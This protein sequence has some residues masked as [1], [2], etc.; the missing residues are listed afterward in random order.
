MQQNKAIEF[1]GIMLGLGEYYSREITKT[2][3]NLYWEGLKEYS[4]EEI[5]SAVTRHIKSP[6]Q[7]VFFP[8]IADLI[9]VLSG[10]SADA[11]QV[12]WSKVDH[13]IRRVGSYQSVAFDDAII[14]RVIADMGGWPPFGQKTEEE[15]PF[16]ANE[17]RQRYRGILVQGMNG[18]HY[19]PILP[20]TQELE[21][22]AYDEEWYKSRGLKKPT[23]VAIGITENVVKVIAGGN[24][25]PLIQVEQ[26]GS[27]TGNMCLPEPN[28]EAA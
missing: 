24:S 3:G 8:K 14:H 21:N 15:W 2:L 13:A 19:P 7:G 5:S 11:A 23:P 25:A 18:L 6:D 1:K 4:I 16:I 17:F 27:I 9:K 20:G 26:I 10:T 28:H 22:S 12:A